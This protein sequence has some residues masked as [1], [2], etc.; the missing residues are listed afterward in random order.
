M[1][2]NTNISVTAKKQFLIRPSNPMPV[3]QAN[4]EAES[5]IVAIRAR[6][7][8]LYSLTGTGNIHIYGKGLQQISDF[9]LIDGVP[10]RG[11]DVDNQGFLWT[12]DQNSNDLLR[13]N[14]NGSLDARVASDTLSNYCWKPSDLTTTCDNSI[15]VAD[16]CGEGRFFVLSYT[17]SKIV[18]EQYNGGDGLLEKPMRVTTGPNR[19][20]YFM[21]QS[22][23]TV[24]QQNIDFA[25]YAFVMAFE[26]GIANPGQVYVDQAENVFI[27][28]KSS[29]QGKFGFYLRQ[30]DYSISFQWRSGSAGSC[31]GG[32]ERATKFNTLSGDSW[33][34]MTT[35]QKIIM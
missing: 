26:H 3:M 10:A 11:L 35:R 14:P 19:K 29:S 13:I 25:P 12:I 1:L 8:T 27:S 34:L 17:N 31:N 30:N 28:V 22:Y 16:Q 32:H 9:D 4:T 18:E 15:V 21:G 33:S 7:D 24:F 6:F 23:V 2:L 5:N 20:L